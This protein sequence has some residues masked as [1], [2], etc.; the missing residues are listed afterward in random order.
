MVAIVLVGGKRSINNEYPDLPDSL[1]P[2]AGEAFLYWVTQWLKTIGFNHIIYSAGHFAERV[3]AWVHHLSSQEPS[4]MLDVVTENR[5]LG[6]AGAT[7]LCANRFPS[8]YTF[9]VNG[10]SILLEDIKPIIERFKSSSNL[11]ALILGANISN[12]GRFGR[13]ETD[14]NQRLVAFKEKHPGSGLINAGVY[15]MRNDLLSTIIPEKETSLENECF[16][17][18]LNDGKHIEVIDSNA[19]FID[20]GTP[21]SLKR[22]QE[23]VVENQDIIL[24]HKDPAKGKGM[25][26]R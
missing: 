19:P 6:T 20:I 23:L 7:A 12:A 15:L 9:V 8:T 5:P 18:W 25:K 10:N 16:P 2:V 1:I 21:E 13:L 17:S 26:S 24:G 14:K 22:A 11:D 4:L 3:N